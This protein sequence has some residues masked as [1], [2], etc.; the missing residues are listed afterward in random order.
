[1][2][3]LLTAEF[4]RSGWTGFALQCAPSVMCSYL[5]LLLV[6]FMAT[7]TGNPTGEVIH[8]NY[9]TQAIR[10]KRA[11]QQHATPIWLDAQAASRVQSTEKVCKW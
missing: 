7:E 3:S 5:C 9:R 10:Q 8:Q 6:K 2:S 4:R 11:A 1:M